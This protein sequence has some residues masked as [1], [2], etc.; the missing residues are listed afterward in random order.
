MYLPKSKYK[1][2][3]TG[4]KYFTLPNGEKYQ[5]YYIETYDKQYFTGKK[6]TKN[7]KRLL[8]QEDDHSETIINFSFENEIILPTEKDYER[9][10]FKRFFIEDKRSNV[11]IEVKLETYN[12]LKPFNFTRTKVIDWELRGPAQDQKI[13]PYIYFGAAAKNKETILEA[14]KTIKGLSEMIN[15]YSQFVR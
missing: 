13:G 11:I 9:G 14:E 1:V 15:N 12:K 10:R 2:L 4:N 5:G 3:N 6:L 8:N 7:S